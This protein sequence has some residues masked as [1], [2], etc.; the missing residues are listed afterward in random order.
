RGGVHWGDH[1]DQPSHGALPPRAMAVSRGGAWRG[2]TVP[3]RDVADASAVGPVHRPTT[4]C[5]RVGR[6]RAVS[7]FPSG[8]FH[9]VRRLV[10]RA[11]S[12]SWPPTGP[13]GT[14]AS[15][16]QCTDNGTKG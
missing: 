9:S 2:P 11:A 4:G 14:H 6:P 12:V 3:R 13:K 8:I 1:G 15:G 10:P 5:R 7:S 16:E